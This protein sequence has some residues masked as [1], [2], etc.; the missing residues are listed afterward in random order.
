MTKFLKKIELKKIK[1]EGQNPLEM[2]KKMV[3]SPPYHVSSP[4]GHGLRLFLAIN[5]IYIDERIVQNQNSI[6][7]IDRV[8]YYY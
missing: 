6:S 1:R 3:E 7:L 2:K 8:P 5:N 4:L